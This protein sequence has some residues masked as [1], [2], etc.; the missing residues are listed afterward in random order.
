MPSTDPV[1]SLRLLWNERALTYG[2]RCVLDLAIPESSFSE[3]TQFQ[4]TQLIPPLLQRLN[5]SERQV[6]DFGA[7]CCRFSAVLAESIDGTC[8]AYDISEELLR[9]SPRHPNVWKVSGPIGELTEHAAAFDLIFIA[10]VLG[11]IPDELLPETVAAITRVA[12]PGALLFFAEHT[13]P[14]G[15]DFWRFRSE[16]AYKTLFPAFAVESVGAYE[17]RG[18]LVSIF[19]GRKR[20]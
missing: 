17:T 14:G 13:G 4:F 1:E 9:I 20:A 12:A 7:G 18:T 16:D 15:N 2:Q 3:M 11:G 19:A 5:G 10:L 6:L 8:F